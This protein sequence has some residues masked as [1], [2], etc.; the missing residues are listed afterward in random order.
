MGT[1]EPKDPRPLYSFRHSFS[2]LALWAKEQKGDFG[3]DLDG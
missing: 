1:Q 2:L 3:L